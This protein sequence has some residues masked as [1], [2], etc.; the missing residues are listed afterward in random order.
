MSQA[1]YCQRRQ[2]QIWKREKTNLNFEV[3][4]CLMPVSTPALCHTR[5]TFYSLLIETLSHSAFVVALV[6]LLSHVQLFATPWA[7]ACQAPLPSTVS[8]SVFK[9]MSI[10]S[11][12][13]SNHL[14]HPLPLLPPSAFNLSHHQS[15]LMSR[16][17]ASSGQSIRDSASVLPTNIQGWFALELT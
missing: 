7:A 4:Q 9:F 14:S 10:A 6:Q 3:L 17:F 13:L 12:M 15:F 11:E 8:W 5:D 1:C 2:R 16:L